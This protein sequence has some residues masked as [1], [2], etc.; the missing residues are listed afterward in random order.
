LAKIHSNLINHVDTGI[1][2]EEGK[3]EFTHEEIGLS[4]K[5]NS[6]LPGG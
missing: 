4:T 6:G 2:S 3:F 1:I 5:V